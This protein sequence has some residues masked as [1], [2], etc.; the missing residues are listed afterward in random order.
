MSGDYTD[1]GKLFLITYLST[2]STSPSHSC[3]QGDSIKKIHFVHNNV[4]D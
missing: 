3:Q 1:I 2:P 4:L